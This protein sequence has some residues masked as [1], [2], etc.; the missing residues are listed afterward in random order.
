[1]ATL[2]AEFI[3]LA[4]ELIGDEFA[5]FAKNAVFER[6]TG[7]DYVTQTGT[8]VT[9][10]VP[11]IRLEYDE[12]QIGGL[13]TVGDFMLIGEYQ[14]FD[15]KPSPDDTFVTF[16]GLKMQIKNVSIDPAGATIKFQVVAL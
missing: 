6:S 15:W 2:P 9:Q 14:L 4:A 12:K 10:T 7:F 1:M 8:L 3:D 5:A 16:D 13:I 11:C